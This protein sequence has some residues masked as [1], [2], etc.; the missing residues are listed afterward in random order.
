MTAGHGALEGWF[1]GALWDWDL[2][3]GVEVLERKCPGVTRVD[4]QSFAHR[5]ANKS[6]VCIVQRTY[7]SD[8]IGFFLLLTAYLLVRCVYPAQWIEI[9]EWR[10]ADGRQIQ[11]LVEPFHRMFY[12]DDM[13]IAF[14]HAEVERVPMCKPLSLPPPSTFPHNNQQH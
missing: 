5:G 14:P 1:D 9:A 6:P 13:R 7:A 3:V 4:V 11:F 8:Y 2:G 12:L 10:T